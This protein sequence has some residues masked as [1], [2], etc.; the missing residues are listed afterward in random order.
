MKLASLA[1]LSPLWPR[2]RRPATQAA[3]SC[4]E[5]SD[6]QLGRATATDSGCWPAGGCCSCGCVC[7]VRLTRGRVGG[8]VAGGG[9]ASASG[10][11]PGGPLASC[12]PAAAPPCWP[13]SRAATAADAAAPSD[14]DEALWTSLKAAGLMRRRRRRFIPPS[15]SCLSRGRLKHD[16][17]AGAGCGPPDWPVCCNQRLCAL[18]DPSDELDGRLRSSC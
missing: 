14:F 13:R 15:A 12:G 3:F 2:R 9:A 7:C 1:P 16:S 11:G 10:W 6:A 5:F 17:I 8:G 4:E 18:H